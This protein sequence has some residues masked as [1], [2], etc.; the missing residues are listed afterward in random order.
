MTFAQ[1]GGEEHQPSAPENLSI[2]CSWL[3]I[4]GSFLSTDLPHPWV[5]ATCRTAVLTVGKNARVQGKERVGWTEKVACCV[6]QLVG[7][8]CPTQ[9]VLPGAL[10][11]PRGVGWG[12]ERDSR[13]RQ[14]INSYG[15]FPLLY[16]RNQ[17]NIVKQSSSTKN[18]IKIMNGLK[19]N[20]CV[21]GPA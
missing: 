2:T 16:G 14:Y 7:G 11:W 3:R 19:N 17:H 1:G 9:G 6:K 20:P 8:C 21:S 4:C 15:W 12:W 13:G 18:K 10:W 5:Q